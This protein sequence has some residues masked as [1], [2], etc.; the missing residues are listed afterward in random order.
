MINDINTSIDKLQILVE[1][2][3]YLDAINLTK[4]YLES[5]IENPIYY[6][7]LTICYI[8]I[9]DIKAWEQSIKRALEISADDYYYIYL[10]WIIHFNKNDYKK[11]KALFIKSLEINPNFVD[12]I[13]SLA[14]IY[15]IKHK[16]S[17]ALAEIKKW[18]LL[19]PNSEDLL[20]SKAVV[21]FALWKKDEAIL[22][23]KDLIRDNPEWRS[24]FWI[25]WDFEMK[26]NNFSKAWEL[27]NEAL[28]GN[29]N[30]E[31]SKNWLLQIY[32]FSNPLYKL[33]FYLWNTFPL[34]FWNFLKFVILSVSI[35]LISS[36]IN[37]TFYS[38][39]F[40][41]LFWIFF[42]R[43]ILWWSTI[44]TGFILSE[45]DLQNLVLSKEYKYINFNLLSFTFIVL[46]AWSLSIY[47][48]TSILALF[49]FFVILSMRVM[50]KHVFKY[51]L[52]HKKNNI[53]RIY[54]MSLT[55]LVILFLA[56]INIKYI[57]FSEMIILKAAVVFIIIYSFFFAIAR[58]IKN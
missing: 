52:K 56:L 24:L 57:N 16:Y 27:F 12:S 36:L 34:L 35:L 37:N 11:S 23:M 39:C 13:S 54:S 51:R 1:Q 2:S 29:P 8:W 41:I 55:S 26:K 31:I 38:L 22:I 6:G 47:F 20:Q 33:H 9:W 28:I 40:V 58:Y 18:L 49:W 43:V 10:L 46:Y 3:R 32:R 53:L 4:Q 50:Q 14:D 42:I 25:L 17:S 7:I 19:E 21:L 48:K 15:I 30:C 45:K 44:A 5:D